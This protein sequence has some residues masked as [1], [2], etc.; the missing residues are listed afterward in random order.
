MNSCEIRTDDLRR[1]A[2]TIGQ[3]GGEMGQRIHSFDWSTTPLGPINQWP[4]SLR[5]VVNILLSS[6]YAM[7][8][9]WGP[10]LTFLWNDAY[11]PTLG[12]KDPWALGARADHVW[13]EIWPDIGPR[14]ETVLT[15]GEATYD[16]GLLLFLERS[17]FPEETYHTFSYSPLAD[18]HG[19][20][21]GMLCVVTEET[22]RLI[23]ERR[24][25]TLRDVASALASTNTEDEVLQ[26]LRDQFSRNQKDLPFTL[27]YLFDDQGQVRLASCTG[28]SPDHPLA[29]DRIGPDSVFPWPAR[30][31]FSS[32]VPRV[33]ELR[34]R[35]NGVRAPMGDWNKPAEKAVVVPIRQQGQEQPAGFLVAGINPYRRYDAAYSGFVDLLAGQI[36]A[37]LANA[38][39]YEAER[40]RAESLAEIDRA[41]T[42]F[43]SNVSHELRTPLTLLLSPVEELLAQQRTAQD[44]EQ[45]QLL[46]LVHRNGLRLQRLV[47]TLLDF[48][49]IEAGRV[50]AV[51]ESTDLPGYTAEL[52]GSFR[53]AMEKAGLEFHVECGQ[54]LPP[55]YVDRDMW[56]KI[57]LNLLS[58]ALK[59]TFE[60]SVHVTLT[61]LTLSGSEGYAELAVRDTGTGIPSS[62][63]PQI[64][65]RFHRVAD[66]QGRSI[67]GTGIGL[68]LVQEL[69]KLNGGSIEVES[70]VS[71]G[72]TFKVRIPFGTEHVPKEKLQGRNLSSTALHSGMFVQEALKWVGDGDAS[73]SAHEERLPE[74]N[75]SFSGERV[76]LADD[77]PDMREYVS[78]LLSG[79]Y[80]VTAVSN[81][82]EALEAAVSDPPDLILSDVMMPGLDG[83][84]LLK[85]LRERAETRTIPVVLLS[86]RA[87]EESRVEGLGAG[88]DDYLIKPFT[89]RELLA[90][91]ASHLSMSRRRREAEEALKQSQ[92]TLQSFYDSS[93]FLMGVIEIVDENI[94]PVYCNVATA[95]FFGV[96]PDTFPSHTGQT[97]RIPRA[98]DDM[99]IL[100]Y[101]RSQREGSSVHFEYQ[102]PRASG[103]IWLSATVNYLGNGPSGRPRFSFLAEDI[104]ERKKQEDLLRRSNQ[105]L[106]RANSDLEQFAY[107]ASHDL[108]EPLRQVAV[109]SQLLERRYAASLDGKASEYLGYCVEGA[110]RMEML[111]SDLLAYSQAA[112][113][114]DSDPQLVDTS[115]VIETVKKNLATRIE[116]TGAVITSEGLPE[117]FGDPVPLMHVF[118]N[119][120][121]NALKYRSDAPPRVNVSAEKQPKFWRFAVSDNGIGIPKKFHE[122]IFGIFKR[123]HARNEYPGTGIGLAICQ[124]VVERYG[125]RIWVESEEGQ[126]ST[127]F[128]TLPDRG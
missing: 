43:F 97:L 62:E 111:I 41:K 106:Q 102:H 77:N 73:V 100:H 104:T 28:I 108:Q 125:G 101:R 118:Q 19:R 30:E 85:E 55:V 110:H 126:G 87:G 96:D 36:A 42:T 98:I 67:E 107:S 44:P 33:E 46:E 5:T 89:A 2:V 23:G 39:A 37:G 48:S 31:I 3:S 35:S 119:L 22:E 16:E 15:T 113:A 12:I 122:Q 40:R 50:Q 13:A 79:R 60:G 99:W 1:P 86:A 63:L 18:D 56:E 80:Q 64:F 94:V 74:T 116:E 120:V 76:L 112:R 114:S 65:E 75:P 7:W 92:A 83:F 115:E 10:E 109:Y 88:A 91:V 8:M 82:E 17:G 27:T 45:R 105:E 117:V 58:N 70:E 34:E 11:R 29:A 47:N 21:N 14:I 78:R 59:F 51:Y 38:R 71:K 128:F 26:A 9:A 84:G 93:S 90:R 81:G 72:S 49:R 69:V 121:S 4:Q 53:S 95:R 20:I 57:V 124:K 25:G 6:R 103:S 66:A 54:Q 52:A 24:V 61:G 123:L 68:A 32:L 127:F